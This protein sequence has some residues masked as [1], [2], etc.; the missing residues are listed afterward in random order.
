MNGLDIEKDRDFIRKKA[1][2][3]YPEA[4]ALLKELALIPAY[5]MQEDARAEFICDW[6][7][8]IESELPYEVWIDEAK[9]VIC[10]IIGSEDED[11]IA[12][13]AAHTDTVFEMSVPRELREENGRLYCPGIGDDTANLV[14]MLMGLKYLLSFGKQPKRTLLFIADSCEEG[15]GNCKGIRTVFENFEGIREF[16][17]FDL[18]LGQCVRGAVGSYRYKISVDAAGGHSYL[19]FGTPNPIIILADIIQS[20]SAIEL[21]KEGHTTFNVG[22]IEGGTS[23]NT[24]PEHAEM[25]YEFRSESQENLEYMERKF[26]RV[27]REKRQEY[28]AGSMQVRI[29][30][31]TCGIRP[32]SAWKQGNMDRLDDWSRRNMEIVQAWYSGDMDTAACSTDAN[33]PLSKGILANMIGTVTGGGAHTLGE[34]IEP[35]SMKAGMCVVMDLAAQNLTKNLSE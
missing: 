12:V 13:L 3:Y 8:Q 32:G 6:I 34:W 27:M 11:D 31:Q 22:M 17:T 28:A 24:I 29:A 2:E 16:Y 15:L 10:R 9:N 18:Y 30:A 14:N 20:L 21:P 26:E 7:G 5:A 1:E 19:A 23:V 33:I 4:L 25:L 35:E